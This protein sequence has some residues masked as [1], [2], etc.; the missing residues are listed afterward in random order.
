MADLQRD[1]GKFSIFMNSTS[2]EKM[3]ARGALDIFGLARA[4]DLRDHD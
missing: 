1:F 2:S 3:R 4:F